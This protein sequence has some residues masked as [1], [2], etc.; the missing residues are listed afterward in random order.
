MMQAGHLT[1]ASITLQSFLRL[2]RCTCSDLLQTDQIPVDL[3]FSLELLFA[4][5][6][7][8]VSHILPEFI[9]TSPGSLPR[10]GTL[11][12]RFRQA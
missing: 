1:S 9:E 8:H 12:Q 2:R 5:A 7:N 4:V 10:G 3:V 6:R 11:S